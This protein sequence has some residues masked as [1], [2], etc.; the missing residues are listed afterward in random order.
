MKILNSMRSYA[1]IF[2]SM[3]GLLLGPGFQVNGAPNLVRNG[4]FED[5]LLV[6]SYTYNWG[7]WAAFP[8]AVD[9]RNWGEVDGTIYQT[10]STTPGQQYKLKYFLAGNKNITSPSVVNAL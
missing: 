1:W 8:G 5:G 7:I 3:T 4:G 6:W 9:G 2:T 10:L